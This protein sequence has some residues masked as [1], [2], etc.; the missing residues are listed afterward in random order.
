MTITNITTSAGTGAVKKVD[1]V[2][3]VTSDASIVGESISIEGSGALRVGADNTEILVEK[4][5]I[6][7]NDVGDTLG[8]PN[9]SAISHNGDSTNRYPIG[10]RFR[11]IDSNILFWNGAAR[12]NIFLSEVTNGV[13]TNGNSTQQLFVYINDAAILNGAKFIDINTLE[14]IGP[15]TEVSGLTVDGADSGYLNWEAGTLVFYG[16]DVQ[17]VSGAHIWLGGGNA[18]NNKGFHWNDSTNVDATK[19]ALSSTANRWQRGY[20]VSY[21]FTDEAGTALENVRLAYSETIEAVQ[22]ELALYTTNASGKLTGT[23]DSNLRSTGSDIERETIHAKTLEVNFGGSTYGPVSPGSESYRLLTVSPTFDIRH[24]DAYEL[25]AYTENATVTLTAP[26]GSVDG[27]G[28]ASSLED[29]ELDTT[30]PSTGTETAALAIT[31]ITITRGSVTW[32]SLDWEYTVTCDTS[33]NPSLTLQDILNYCNAQWSTHA[34]F[35]GSKIH[36]F[37]GTLATTRRSDDNLGVR[38]V[39]QGGNPFPGYTSM[40]ANSGEYVPPVATPFEVTQLQTGSEIRVYVAGTTTEVFG[41]ESNP[42]STYTNNVPSNVT[43]IDVSILSL[44]Y[45][46]VYF[47]SIPATGAQ[48]S[49]P[50]G[51]DVDR[52]YENP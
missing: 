50:A 49:L 13:V 1:T 21:I 51:Q 11:M 20:T 18:G 10:R 25:A 32:N 31:G 46:N 8:H 42:T 23:F 43:S 27:A 35:G 4:S 26:I 30:Y 19:I 12:R 38:V 41:I 22:T 2:Q 33:V 52:Q 9:L 6:T 5:L 47:E 37:M 36:Q 24:F 44:S 29:F 39:D 34:L 17:N 48:I 45:K 28:V 3:N 7:V 15:P 16:Y 40:Q 14:I